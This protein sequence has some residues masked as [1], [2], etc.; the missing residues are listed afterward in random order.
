MQRLLIA[1]ESG[2]TVDMKAILKHELM[3][4]PLALAE[5]NGSLRD[6]SKSILA[7]MIIANIKIPSSIELQGTSCLIIDGQALVVALGR[8]TEAKTFG[9]FANIFT[10]TVLK[11]GSSFDRV[12]VVFD[13]YREQSIKAST[14]E[15]RTKTCQPIRRLVEGPDVPLPA[16]WNNFLALPENKAD[17]AKFLSE[18]LSK[19]NPLGKELVVAGGYSNEEEVRSTNPLTNV[20]PLRATHEEADTRMVLHAIHC[21]YTSIVVSSKDTD[22][23][24]LLV[25]HRHLMS[26]DH[27]WMMCGTKVKRK[28]IPIDVVLQQLP[29][30]SESSLL[31]FHALTG[32]DSTSFISNH[33]KH[34]AFKVFIE[35]HALLQQL[36][37]GEL[38]AQVIANAENFICKLYKVG[39]TK[40]VDDAR[41]ILFGKTTKPEALPPTSDA[42]YQH[43]KRV[44]YQSLIWN[45]APCAKPILPL[46]ADMG[47]RPEGTKL[48]PIL[49]TL[50][51]IPAACL[52]TTTCQCSTGCQNRRC[53]CRKLSLVCSANCGCSNNSLCYNRD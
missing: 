29:P 21:N 31:A 53:K 24:A 45:L 46:P 16:N 49:M 2:R 14:R 9:D 36:G 39:N 37:K 48:L 3:P 27:L 35:H 30:G 47:W 34:T 33:T 40:S 22:V 52:E 28:Y 1:Y 26:C 6:G 20:E 4:V 32:C 12:D 23:L 50:D 19:S 51:S 8:P 7:D 18:E 44:H 38:S 17:L 13:R 11:A 42:L 10:Q 15:K 25:A 41:Y 5:L 43:L